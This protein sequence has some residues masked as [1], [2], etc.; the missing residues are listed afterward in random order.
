MASSSQIVENQQKIEL[1]GHDLER[2]TTSNQETPPPN[3]QKV[4][5]LLDHCIYWLICSLM[6]LINI[7]LNYM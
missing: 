1:N 6:V 3:P 5:I 4:T 2:G 7:G